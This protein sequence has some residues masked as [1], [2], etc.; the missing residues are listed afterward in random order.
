[1]SRRAEGDALRCDMR[2]GHAG[3]VRGDELRHVDQHRKRWQRA[4][5]RIDA[6]GVA[7]CPPARWKIAVHS[8][9]R[10]AIRVAASARVNVP[11]S[12]PAMASQNDARPTANPMKPGTEAA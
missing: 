8:A 5:E 10:L 1:M 11:A 6:H 9:K 2:I 7:P 4:R 3:V 12:K